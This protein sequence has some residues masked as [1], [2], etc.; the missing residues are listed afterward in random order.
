MSTFQPTEWDRK[1]GH[2][3]CFCI[4]PIDSDFLSNKWTC[5][6]WNSTSSTR[7]SLPGPEALPV[8]YIQPVVSTC[9]RPGWSLYPDGPFGTASI[10][11][12]PSCTIPSQH[13]FCSLGK[14]LA[15]A[16]LDLVWEMT[17][18]ATKADLHPSQCFLALENG[19]V[20]QVIG[21]RRLFIDGNFNICASGCDTKVQTKIKLSEAVKVWHYSRFTFNSAGLV[22]A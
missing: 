19:S 22:T 17:G 15:Q 9:S 6:C 1:D 3:G 18:E 20:V 7:P 8:F 21:H 12:S 10:M 14:I 4:E 2:E 5:S 11:L 16:G 13:K